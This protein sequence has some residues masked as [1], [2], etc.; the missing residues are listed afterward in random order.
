[1]SVQATTLAPNTILYANE[2]F[3]S[4]YPRGAFY[5]RKQQNTLS[6]NYSRWLNK[7]VLLHV[8]TGGLLSVLN[9]VIVSESDATLQVRIG[10]LWDVD[11]FKEMIVAVQMG[12]SVEPRLA[13]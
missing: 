3:E 2:L 5:V 9:C 6:G 10:N 12:V 4:I 13:N 7:P 8:A 11:V 1:M